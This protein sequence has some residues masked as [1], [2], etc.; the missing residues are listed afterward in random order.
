MRQFSELKRGGGTPY[1]QQH[2]KGGHAGLISARHPG[3]P[4]F[5]GGGLRR[6]ERKLGR[7]AGPIRGGVS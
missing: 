2:R 1:P 7:L 3:S 4:T 5:A 6:S